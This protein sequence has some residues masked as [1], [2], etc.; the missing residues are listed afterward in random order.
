MID[1][2]NL[3]KNY[4]G[5]CW[6]TLAAYFG[7]ICTGTRSTTNYPQ[8]Y[9]GFFLGYKRWWNSL[10]GQSFLNH[11]SLTIGSKMKYFV[12][13]FLVCGT[14]VSCAEIGLGDNREE[15]GKYT[16]L[17]TY[18]VVFLWYISAA[19]PVIAGQ[20]NSQCMGRNNDTGTCQSRWACSRQKGVASGQCGFASGICCTRKWTF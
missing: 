16:F 14:L 17:N 9:R 20:R 2:Q 19:D 11:L 15:R 8:L 18:L 13:A 7:I 4:L 10:K 12:A 1:I 5:F 6:A 3:G